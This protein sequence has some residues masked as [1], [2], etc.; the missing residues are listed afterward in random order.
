MSEI[1]L[2]RCGALLTLL[3]TFFFAIEVSAHEAVSLPNGQIQFTSNPMS[4]LATGSP[5]QS[6]FKIC[7]RKTY[8]AQWICNVNQIYTSDNPV[9]LSGFS[10]NQNYRFR[11]FCWC[12]T[13]TITPPAWVQS[14]DLVFKYVA[15]PP[16][17]PT[18][19]QISNVRIREVSSNHCIY[20]TT[21]DSAPRHG[22]CWGDPNMTYQRI[23]FSN[24][25]T[26][27]KHLATGRC[28]W[29]WKANL[30]NISSTLGC[31]QLGTMFVVE[32]AGSGKFRLNVPWTSGGGPF[33]S[34][35]P[36]GC[37]YVEGVDGSPVRKAPCAQDVKFKFVLDPA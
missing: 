17:V 5:N 27:F 2:S 32:V 3:F 14:G 34:M 9:I 23:D 6:S 16:V 20:M 13:G 18:I 29:G 26:Q 7:W 1:L 21:V 12:M 22:G 33:N 8:Q 19:V 30:P 25:A 15:P 10:N 4:T 24:G 28:L 35:G 11:V 37:I 31:G 36:G